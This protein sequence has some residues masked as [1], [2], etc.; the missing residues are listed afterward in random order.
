MPFKNPR[1]RKR[2]PKKSDEIQRDELNRTHEQQIARCSDI[3]RN[4]KVVF[5]LDQATTILI[6][7]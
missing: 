7:L 2:K 3:S 4:V 5:S 6:A 1:K